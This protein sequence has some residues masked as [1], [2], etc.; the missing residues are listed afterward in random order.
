MQR[1]IIAIVIVVAMTLLGCSPAFDWREA[2]FAPTPLQAVFP[3]KPVRETRTVMLAGESL[4]MQMAN[5]KTAGVTTAIGFVSLVNP[6]SL[7]PT[8]DQWQEATLRTLQART[9]SERAFPL[10]GAA[11]RPAARVVHA[12]G[13]VSNGAQVVLDAVWFAHGR[14]AFVAMMYGAP[15][16]AETLETF[17][18]GLRLP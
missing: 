17:Q 5:C 11:T 2:R 7:G 4:E 10:P 16:T 12:Q 3:C 13:Q 6:E 18:A 15:R 8:L 1:P 9:V 14:T